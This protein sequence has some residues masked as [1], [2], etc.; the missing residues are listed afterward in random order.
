MF[1][2][3]QETFNALNALGTTIRGRGRPLVVWLG[4][5]AGAWAGYPLWRDLAEQMHGRFAREVGTY[6][7][8]T[9]TALLAADAYPKL[10]HEMRTS[11]SALYFSCLM[12]AFAY[13]QPTPIWGRLLRALEQVEPRGI[14]TTNVDESLERDLS[15]RENI[16]R[17]DIERMLQLLSEDRAFLCKLHGS[18][19]AV[20]TMVFSEQDYVDIQTDFPFCNALSSLFA[21][22][23]VLFLGYG[24]RDQHVISAV[25]EGSETHPLLGTGPHFIITPAG[26]S[27][28][29]RGVRRISYVAD[30]PDHRSALLTLEAVADIRARPSATASAPDPAGI[31]KRDGESICFIG[32][33]LPPGTFATSHTVTAKNRSGTLELLIGEGYVDGEVVL[34]DY[35]ALHDVVVGLVCFDVICLS[36]EHLGKLHNLLGSAWFWAFVQAE[37]IRLV[38]PPP[39]PAVAFAEPGALVG[40][41]MAFQLGSKL[42]SIESFQ[43]R[44][45]SEIIRQH[46]KPVPGNENPAERLMDMLVSSTVDLAHVLTTDQVAD[47]TRGAMMHPSIRRLLGISGGTPQGA[48]PRWLAFPVLRL[49]GVVRKGVICQQIAAIATR[50]VLGSERLASVAFSADAGTEWADDAASYALTGRFNSD[51]GAL[52]E[53]QPDLLGG[54]LGFRESTGGKSFRREVAERLATNEGGQVIAAVNAGLREALPTSVLQAA[55]DQ[56]SGLFLPRA[57]GMRLRPAVWGDLRNAEDRVARWRKRSRMLLDGLCKDNRLNPYDTCPCGSGE[58]IRFCCAAALR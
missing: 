54:V 50:L 21:G 20:E 2:E 14:L 11:D 30:P 35:S 3:D 33:L 40:D 17:S 36:I 24:L 7:K 45:I 15:G 55:R 16:Q 42:S 39:E 46:L 12:D 23:T 44:T 58:K 48:V 41:I 56:L 31:A 8:K 47:R 18:I 10:F 32:D 26:S 6:S 49:A 34:R 9:G 29:P 19:S 51:L 25:E 52:I 57:A 1:C 28:V 38:N 43:E 5:G 53:Q 37:A 13:R 22:S 27:D 4:A